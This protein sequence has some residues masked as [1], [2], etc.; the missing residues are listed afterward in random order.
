M[1]APR[2]RSQPIEKCFHYWKKKNKNGTEPL[3]GLY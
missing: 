2:L 1:L 3:D